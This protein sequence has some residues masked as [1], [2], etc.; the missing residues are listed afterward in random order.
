MVS[1]FPFNLVKVLVSV[2]V[3]TV[4]QQ[5]SFQIVLSRMLLAFINVL[6]ILFMSV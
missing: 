2:A 3:L 6:I 4:T 5:I 1:S